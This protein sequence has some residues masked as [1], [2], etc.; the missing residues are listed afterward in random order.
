MKLKWLSYGLYSVLSVLLLTGKAHTANLPVAEEYQV[1]AVF[2]FNFSSY[3]TWPA[4]A[5]T[6]PQSPFSICI[7]GQDPFQTE[8]DMT[9]EGE[10]ISG[11]PVVIQRLNT[12]N[13]VDNCQI[14][15]VSQSENSQL[16]N[17]LTYLKYQRRPILTVSDIENFVEQGGMI[18]F[19]KNGKK[20]RF[21]ID[22]QAAKNA[23]LWVSG[24]LLSIA[25]VVTH[26]QK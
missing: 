26:S 6:S 4:T 3:I 7:L 24:N 19:F 14:L 16:T 5:F 22:H 18:Q 9:V 17:I 21:M 10:K 13:L 12:L 15:F 20:V 1:K 2:L 23:G 11:H 8:L 25:E